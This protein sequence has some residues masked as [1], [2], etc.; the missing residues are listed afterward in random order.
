MSKTYSFDVKG[1]ERALEETTLRI[2]DVEVLIKR[3]IL[4]INFEPGTIRYIRVPLEFS[5]KNNCINI[6]IGESTK[7]GFWWSDDINY[8]ELARTLGH[9]ESRATKLKLFEFTC[10]TCESIILLERDKDPKSC[11]YCSGPIECAIES[12]KPILLYQPERYRKKV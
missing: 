9:I 12:I 7:R 1:F 6:Y 5:G 10:T 11:P 3:G 4:Y 2:K 8:E